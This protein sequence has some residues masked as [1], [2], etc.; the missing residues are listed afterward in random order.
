MESCD[1]LVV[2][3]GPAGS[4]CARALVQAGL[5][6]VVL[7]KSQFPRDKVCAGWI[8]P[9]VVSALQIDPEDYRQTRTMQ[10]IT[11]FRTGLGQQP[12]VKVDY[13]R[14]VSYGI[15]RCEFD[16]YL[17][18]RSGA[19]LRLGEPLSTTVRQ[20]DH[21]VINDSLTTPLIIG[22]GGHF[23]PVA[24]L[25]GANVG[26][27]E[28]AITAQE[29]EFEMDA[30]QAQHCGVEA[31]TPELYFCD[32][33]KGYAWCFR[34]GNFLNVGLGREDNH[35]LAEQL[36]SFWDW[37]AAQGKLPAS[38]PARFKGHAYLLSTRSPRKIV[39]DGDIE[40]PG[41]IHNNL[42]KTRINRHCR[43]IM[44]IIQD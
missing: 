28:H 11:A 42:K 16:D 39:D 37:L 34:K 40:P 32:D 33:L 25:L 7:D 20:D 2:G 19:R 15:R 9:Q 6:V 24:K 4:S 35:G 8:T 23:C 26:R 29:I 14:T 31:S 1:A 13:D 17:L 38:H 22:A 27:G 30:A 18:R 41:Q 44:G 12:T 3:G 21:W 43:R 10:P 36:Q 5:D